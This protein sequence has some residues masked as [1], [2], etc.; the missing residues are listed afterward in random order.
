MTKLTNLSGIEDEITYGKYLIL[1][2]DGEEFEYEI[3]TDEEVS[4][5]IESV[6]AGTIVASK[7]IED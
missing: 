5:Y 3:N 4:N 7:R 6:N 1:A 2:S